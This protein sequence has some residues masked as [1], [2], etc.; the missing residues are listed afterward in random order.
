MAENKVAEIEIDLYALISN[1]AQ[2]FLHRYGE[3]PRYVI[4]PMYWSW[5]LSR[6]AVIVKNGNFTLLGMQICESPACQTVD[7]IVV[8]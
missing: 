4:L 7:D 6:Y 1:K 3:S 2:E 5:M 8:Y